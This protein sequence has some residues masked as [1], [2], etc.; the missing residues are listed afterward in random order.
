MAK[1][2]YRAVISLVPRRQQ[3]QLLALAVL[4]IL[5]NLLDLVGLAG[6]ALLATTFGAIASGTSRQSPIDLPIIGEVV[7]TEIEAVVIALAIALTFVLKSFFSILLNLRTALKVAEIEGDFAERL[8]RNYFSNEPSFEG[9][10]NETVSRFQNSILV[11]TAGLASFLNARISFLAEASLLLALVVVFTVVNPVATVA[12]LIYLGGV[13]AALNRV[14]NIRLKRNSRRVVEGSERALSTSRDLFGVRREVQAAGHLES[15]LT[16]IVSGKRQAASGTGIN[17]TINSLPRYVIETSLILGIFAFLGGVVIFSDLASQSV[18]IG[19]FMAGGLRLVASILPIQAAYNGMVSA[20]AA[21]EVALKTLVAI[22]A[23]PASID[24]T[25]NP[26][27]DLNKAA[28]MDF[29]S[30][31][32]RYPASDQITVDKVTFRVPPNSK[33][34]IVGPSGAGKTT[35]FELAT[36]FKVPREG[37]IRISG[38]SPR[39]LLEKLP[40]YIGIVPQRPHLITGTLAENISLEDH[41]ATNLPRVAFCLEQAGLGN[42]LGH[43]NEGLAIGITP[44]SGHLSGG[45]IQRLGLARALYRQP[46]IL[47]LDEATSALDAETE[48]RISSVLDELRTDMTIVLIAHRLSTV[49]NADNII[50]LNKGK[51]VAQGTFAELKK[52]VPDF[53]KAVELMD[54]GE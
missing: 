11:S 48:S 13:I 34:A 45:E 44:D 14:I 42:F 39:S 10:L 33:T 46:R 31:T 20:G 43:D 9:S 24:S 49:M 26:V 41:S 53:A 30:V 21:G 12:I 38:T 37:K 22:S 15:W 52:L 25:E 18:T 51:V 36:G 29:Q 6:I 8:T 2:S 5:A 35:V 32:F 17:Y 7:I 28:D 4:R 40:G 54:L 23:L 19:V 3:R 16:S 50:Y 1:L 47:F 27:M